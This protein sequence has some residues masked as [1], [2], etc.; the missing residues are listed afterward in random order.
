[1]ELMV[2]ILWALQI[3]FWCDRYLAPAC[4]IALSLRNIDYYWIPA[5]FGMD[6]TIESEVMNILMNIK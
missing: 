1:M 5:L 2:D 3:Y 4:E 6:K